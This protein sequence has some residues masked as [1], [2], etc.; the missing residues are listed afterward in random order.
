MVWGMKP[1]GFFE[2]M[3][4]TGIKPNAITFINLLIGCS[5]AGLVEEGLN[6]F[7]SMESVYGVEPTGE[8][9]ACIIDL[10]G[11][12]G[13]LKEAEEFI[14]CMPFEP[15]AFG[16]CSYLGAC[17]IHG[18]KSRAEI[19][20][21]KLLKLEPDNSSVHILLS[22]IY[23]KESQWEEVSSLR[24]MI[25]DGNL[26]KLPG[27]SWVDV[28]NKTHVFGVDDWSHPQ[29]REIYEKLDSLLDDIKEVGYIPQKDVISIVTDDTT[30][31][32]MLR[33]HSEKIAVAFALMAMPAWKP[34]IIKKNLRI[35][36]DCHLAIK[37]IAKV[38]ERTIIV[39][40]NSRFHHFSGG[41]CSCGDYW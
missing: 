15:N 39:R 10:L 5:H 26:K 33:N 41:S 34:I 9:Y 29:Q 8:H 12:A 7:N 36:P 1:L 16:W 3:V 21:E 17:R 6:L 4:H 35:C 25:K 38:V 20:A 40:D 27:Y 13:K 24:K 23:A 31:E 37:L 14:T 19:A 28:G 32:K 11:R 2:R 22:N 18:D 30:K